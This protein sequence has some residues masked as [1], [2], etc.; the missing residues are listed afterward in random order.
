MKS[1]LNVFSESTTLWYDGTSVLLMGRRGKPLDI[2]VRRMEKRLLQ[3]VVSSSMDMIG[4]PDVWR[5]LSTYVASYKALLEMTEG[6]VPE[7]SDDRPYL[8]YAILRSAPVTERTFAANLEMFEPHLESAEIL[9]GKTKMTQK[10][11]S[12]NWRGRNLL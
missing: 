3:P 2:D 8:E 6:D 12:G 10:T 7:N 5:L 4:N 9:I 1:F 11:T